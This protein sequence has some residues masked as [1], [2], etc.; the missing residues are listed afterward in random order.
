MIHS[1]YSK[2]KRHT[3]NSDRTFECK[4]KRRVSFIITNTPNTR[5]ARH[6]SKLNR[7]MKNTEREEKN[8]YEINMCVLWHTFIYVYF[9]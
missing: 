4:A 2:H 8:C 5:L 6:I 1:I 7:M 9:N 3:L